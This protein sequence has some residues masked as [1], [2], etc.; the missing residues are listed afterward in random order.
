M[1]IVYL[2]AT[3]E[4]LALGGDKVSPTMRSDEPLV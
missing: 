2:V 3:H 4:A 1:L